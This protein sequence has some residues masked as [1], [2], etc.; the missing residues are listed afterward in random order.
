ML[1]PYPPRSAI[2]NSRRVIT[3]DQPR[4]QTRPI[5]RLLSADGDSDIWGWSWTKSSPHADITATGN[6]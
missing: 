3:V 4:T 2:N 5:R 1:N 6:I